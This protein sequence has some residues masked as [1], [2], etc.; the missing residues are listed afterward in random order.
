MKRKLR[1]TILFTFLFIFILFAP[2]LTLHFQGYRIDLEKRRLTQ[3]GGFFLKTIPKQTEIYL[4][5]K[6][7]KKTDF[8]FGS[9][10]I[11]GLLPKKYNIKVKKDGYSTW[12]K[13][14]GIKEKEVTEV[15]DVV[16][17]PENLPFKLLGK[18]VLDIW[19]SK[20]NKTI[21][22]KE[23]KNDSWSLKLYNLEKNLKSLLLDER[24]LSENRAELIVL[25]FSEEEKQINL[26]VIIKEQLKNFLIDI[27]QE[28][29]TP[30]KVSQPPLLDENIIV[31]QKDL[32]G[33]IYT[34]DS[35][36]YLY[37]NN[38][39]LSIKEKITKEPFTLK[40]ETEYTIYP[41]QDF[42]FLKDGEKNLYLLD[43]KEGVLKKFSEDVRG[44]EISPD[45]KKLAY[46]SGREIHILFLKEENTQPI[47]EKGEDLFLFRL[48][49]EITNIF[50]ITSNYLSFS[51]ENGI[52]VSE[53]DNRDRINTVTVAEF[54]NSEIFWNSDNK[55]F[56]VLVGEN[57]W[58]SNKLLP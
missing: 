1:Q 13:T 29:L 26:E 41:F 10:L 45:L 25:K 3:T 31:A 36:G 44:L 4:N 22:W 23:E 17:F 28:P 51:T 39:F 35:F 21:V 5:E 49:E 18:G 48:S 57:L 53:I 43:Q 37:K 19:F 47:R 34:L 56:Y 2:I 6:F 32:N 15:K 30:K 33:N 11:E 58:V 24:D 12:E 7:S 9:V 54:K 20:D 16:L 27:N 52:K 8:F 38:T 55:K 50:W 42:I 14:L 40:Q 46:F